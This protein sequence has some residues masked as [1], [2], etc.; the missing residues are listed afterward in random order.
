MPGNSSL[1][2][3][4]LNRVLWAPFIF[5]WKRKVCALWTFSCA[6]PWVGKVKPLWQGTRGVFFCWVCR[7]WDDNCLGGNFLLWKIKSISS[8]ACGLG[9]GGD[10]AE[11]WSAGPGASLS[12]LSS[13][14]AP[15]SCPMLGGGGSG[16]DVRESLEVL[17]CARV[18]PASRKMGEEW[19]LLALAPWGWKSLRLGHRLSPLPSGG[20]EPRW[21]PPTFVWPSPQ[22]LEL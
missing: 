13:H 15:S 19:A 1:D 5:T 4:V 12:C 3:R 16:H 18:K 17:T 7:D 14:L 11:L 6:L 8:V 22:W 9:S 21:R 10:S 2:S 20:S